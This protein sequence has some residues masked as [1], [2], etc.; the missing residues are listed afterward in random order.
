MIT[1]EIR[2]DK[3]DSHQLGK[4]KRNQ[5]TEMHCLWGRS[6]RIESYVDWDCKSICATLRIYYDLMTAVIRGNWIIHDYN[7]GLRHGWQHSTR[8]EHRQKV[9]FESNLCLYKDI[10][11]LLWLFS[12]RWGQNLDVKRKYSC[13]RGNQHIKKQKKS[14]NLVIVDNDH[15][16]NFLF[17]S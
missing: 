8:F 6:C 3:S 14:K 16:L 4:K 11:A 7:C 2:H 1:P 12:P 13:F 9:T 5:M 17:K 10:L 15:E